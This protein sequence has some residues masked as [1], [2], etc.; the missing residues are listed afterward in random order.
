LQ[1]RSMNHSGV[2]EPKK[3]WASSGCSVLTLCMLGCVGLDRPLGGEGG[4]LQGLTRGPGSR[5][6]PR[7]CGKLV[8]LC[9]VPCVT[10]L[11]KWPARPRLERGVWEPPSLDGTRLVFLRP[12]LG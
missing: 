7:G 5:L 3:P 2:V 1:R 11:W 12:G 9:H 10:L 8:F 6:A 4:R